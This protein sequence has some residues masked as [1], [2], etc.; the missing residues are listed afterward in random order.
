[1]IKSR[2]IKWA[3]HVARMGRWKMR[4]R[5]WLESLKVTTLGRPMCKWEDNIQMELR[6]IGGESVVWILL[7]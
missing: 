7:A 1:M 3:G 6:E 2:R 5:F 4:T